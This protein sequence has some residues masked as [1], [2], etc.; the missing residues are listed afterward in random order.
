MLPSEIRIIESGSQGNRE[1]IKKENTC[2]AAELPR[3]VKPV[4][5][6][7]EFV[8]EDKDCSLFSCPEPGCVKQYITMGKLEKHI[9]A[10]KHSFQDVSEPLGDKVIK[11]WAEQFQQVTSENLSSQL[12]NKL[13]SLR[14][15][16][17]LGV[18][19]HQVLQKGWALKVPKRASRFHDKVRNYLQEKFDVVYART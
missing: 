15:T 4:R 19:T 1:S 5:S 17:D 12:E 10:E 11:K 7:E 16:E 2:L 6:P 9:A 18:T 8:D 14:L 3:P 13:S